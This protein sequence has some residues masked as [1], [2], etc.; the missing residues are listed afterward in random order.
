MEEY[1]Q[2]DNSNLFYHKVCPDFVRPKVECPGCLKY[3]NYN[4]INSKTR[5][6]YNCIKKN[7]KNLI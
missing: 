5:M 2:V 4:E 6:C 1:Y 7:I 3:I